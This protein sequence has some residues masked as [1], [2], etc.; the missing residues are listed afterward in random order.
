MGVR[1][2]LWLGVG[3]LVALLLVLA[4]GAVWQLRTMSGQMQALVQG[5]GHRGELAHRLHAAQLTWMER[6]RA[7]LLVT[8]PEDLKAQR[9]DLQAAERRYTEAE[10]ALDEALKRSEVDES[11]R[12]A[13]AEV[14]QLHE[15]VAPLYGSVVRSMEGGAGTEGALALLL[16]A[17]AAEARWRKLLD[18]LVDSAS[19]AS[20]EEFV[21]AS[22][23]Q[24]LATLVLGAV[25]LVAIAA[26]WIMAAALVRGI[27]RPVAAAMAV[28]EAI[29]QGRLDEPIDLSRRDEFGRL[30]AAMA[31]M[32]ARLRDTVGALTTSSASVMSASRELG[33]VSQD[34]SDRTEQAAASLAETASAVRG[35][36]GTVTTGADAARSA[37]ALVGSA[38]QGAQQG[39]AAVAQ[40]V[41]HMQSIEAAARRIT[42]IV[43][44]IDG[45]AFQTNIL[46]LNASVEAARAGEQGRG[47]AVVAAEVRELA[48]RAAEAAGQI[49]DLSTDT[50]H[51]IAQGSASVTAVQ[52]TMTR[53]VE[54]ARGVANTVEG[55]ATATV[56]Q[57]EVLGRVD[58]AVLQL[59]GT[60][61]QNAA[62]AEQLTAAAS[63][64][65]QRAGELQR[66]IASFRVEPLPPAEVSP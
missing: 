19:R 37:S 5:H 33:V 48:Q 3:F 56:Q 63:T 49:R 27:T 15:S 39:H 8:D 18:T 54:A 47:F 21:R 24:E 25:A 4:S 20:Q 34:L 9:A 23:R 59:D 40:L 17:E 50:S 36:R 58:V 7:L 65:H 53:L 61:Q 38:Q 45:I 44:V 26:A 30:A 64:L 2:R 10:T 41:S 52:A 11:M 57:S 32:Q 6:L 28:A 55:I 12:S 51:S 1:Q 60:T 35:L 22:R 16:P 62:L 13:L 29:A 14:R 43:S 66:S 31:T 46:A 42:E